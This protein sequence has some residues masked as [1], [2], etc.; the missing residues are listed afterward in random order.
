MYHGSKHV[1]VSNN[2]VFAVL[3]SGRG[4]LRRSIVRIK[5][6]AAKEKSRKL[7]TNPLF[8]LLARV[9]LHVEGCAARVQPIVP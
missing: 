8:L 3:I 9:D 7:P 1:R 6:C 4:C 2:D 5:D